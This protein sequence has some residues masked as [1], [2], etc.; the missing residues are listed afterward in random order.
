MLIYLSQIHVLGPLSRSSAGLA[1]E[2]AYQGY[3]PNSARF[4]IWL[5]APSE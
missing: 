1:D 4:Q 2:L 3:T 5:M